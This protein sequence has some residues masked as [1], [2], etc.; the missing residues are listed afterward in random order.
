MLLRMVC[1]VG[2]VSGAASGQ[3]YDNLA[4][5]TDGAAFFQDVVLDDL[6]VEGGGLL[7]SVTIGLTSES[8]VV[9]SDLVLSIALDGGDGVP[10]LDGMGDDVFIVQ[11][12]APGV[13]VSA[14]EVTEVTFDVPGW[15]STVPPGALLFAGVQSS[16]PSVGHVFYGAPD[17]GST[18]GFVFSLAG[19][20]PVVV[21]GVEDPDAFPNSLGLGFRIEAIELP[22]EAPGE[23]V[24]G[25]AI[26]FESLGEGFHGMSQ[27]I[28]GVTFFDAFS[29]FPPIGEETLAVD[30]A[31]DTWVNAPGMLDFVDGNIL[32]INAFSGGPSSY[33][34]AIWKRLRMSAP[35]V[36][37]GA[38]VSVAY[39]VEDIIDGVD[40]SSSEIT[41]LALLDGEPVATDVIHPDNVLGTSPGGSFSFGAGMLE[42]SG[43]EFD[44]LVL[45]TN[46]PGPFGT[47]RMGI[48][49]VVIGT[50][51][52]VA[53][54]NGDGVLNILDFVS[55]QGAFQ[56]GDE[57]ADVN[58]DGE[59]D[60]LDFVIFQQL[61]VEGCR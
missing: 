1:A 61:F 20:G 25:E 52:C 12:S 14:G 26:G 42:I 31:T 18:D 22:G 27:T 30:D 4:S 56:A 54:F 3:I 49:N 36:R 34:F 41:L 48:D 7:E 60:I 59:L 44:A 13:E 58:G 35:E 11:S 55:F 39:V 15:F 43:V 38:Q 8:G 51:G 33:A 6:T 16:D 28:D 37:T 9:T 45:F 40:F 53:D 21:P 29:G 32:N 57:R 46:G 23:G 19:M 5:G 50:A 24:E 10:S 47:V 17:P 2:L